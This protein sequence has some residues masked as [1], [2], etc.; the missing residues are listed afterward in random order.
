MEACHMENAQDKQKGFRGIGLYLILF[1]V[2]FLGLGCWFYFDQ[3]GFEAK[4]EKTTGT[5]IEVK[6]EESTT[7]SGNRPRTV[8]VYRPVIRFEAGGRSYTFITS[9]A[10]SSYNYKRGARLDILY[11][12]ANPMDARLADDLVSW[13]SIIFIGVGGLIV[14]VGVFLPRMLK[15]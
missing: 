3:R 1:G 5:V 4:A 9:S 12:P 11:D 14:I 7:T 6:R 2:L 15:K 10:S 8:V 13:I